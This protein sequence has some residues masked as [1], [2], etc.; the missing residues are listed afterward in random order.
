MDQSLGSLSILYIQLLEGDPASGQELWKRC[1]PRLFGL[2]NS[3]LRN[4]QLAQGAEDAVQEAFF[5]FLQRVRSGRYADALRRD[6]MW[7]ILGQFT[8]QRARKILRNER[9]KKRGGGKVF[10]ESE[11]ARSHSDAF[12]LDALFS[13]IATV[14]CDM[15]FEEL[16]SKLDSELRE[17]ALLRLAGYTNSEIKVL[18]SCSLR[19]VER[20]VQLIRSI[21]GEYAESE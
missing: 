19:S 15:I 4:H 9:T 2:A 10:R 20:R 12:K 18:Q 7:R 3:V 11:L 14:D 17:I 6:D 16:L 8:V 5:Q 1:F 21:W 13:T